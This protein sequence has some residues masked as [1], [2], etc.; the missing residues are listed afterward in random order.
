MKRRSVNDSDYDEADIADLSPI[1]Q[2]STSTTGSRRRKRKYVP[3]E[4]KLDDP[5][6]IKM[7]YVRDSEKKVRDSIYVVL[8]D[9][10]GRGLSIDEACSAVEIVSNGLFGREFKPYK[11]MTDE[12]ED[13]VIDQNTLP[14][15]RSIRDKLDKIEAHGLAVASKEIE[16]QKHEG[17]TIVHQSDS[18]TKKSVGK[19]SVSGL[20]VNGQMI[21]LPTI[22][23]AGETR[24]EIADQIA[25]GFRILGA[26]SGK[27]AGDIYSLVDAHIPDSVSHNKGLGQDVPKLFNLDTIVG[28]LFCSTHTNLGFCKAL[29]PAIKELENKVG[30]EN[31]LD[32]FLVT[33]EKRSKNG[34]LA[35][36]FVDC[37][38]RLVGKELLH[39][40]WNRA[41]DFEK[42]CKEAGDHYKMFLYKDERFGCFP[43]ACAVCIYSRDLL[44]EFLTSHPDIDNKLACIVRDVYKQEY[45]ELVLAVVAAFGL[46]LIEPFHAKTISKSSTHDSLTIFFRNLHEAME[47]PIDVSFFLL[48]KPWYPGVSQRLFDDVKEGYKSHVVKSIV[49]VLQE[50]LD[51]A[52]KLGNYFQPQL[53]ITLARQRRDYGLSS[54]FPPE[55]PVQEFPSNVREKAPVHNL[56]ME[57]SCGKVGYRTK[58][59]RDLNATSRALIIE[60]TKRLREKHG[61][62]FRDYGHE[63]R[64]IKKLKLEWM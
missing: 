56:E 58:E 32:S 53:K 11:E 41:K 42:W 59:N 46:Q 4:E 39:K 47:N 21:P 48:E 55:H 30:V 34:S 40:Q 23:V 3:T 28:Q 63:A 37:I 50:N 36:Q 16:I 10:V 54:D 25:L 60:G 12:T 45:M 18:T 20:N 43:K 38:T 64:A 33:I 14:D 1:S 31:I 15:K 13:I 35:G 7:R 26:A 57:S 52:V 8:S 27:D 62:S 2:A 17:A 29:N 9:L 49:S 22:P 61:G 19:F 44:N 51:G 5:L 24:D 6:P